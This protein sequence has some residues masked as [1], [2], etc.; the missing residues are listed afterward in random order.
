MRDIIITA[1]GSARQILQEDQT[2]L[3]ESLARLAEYEGAA[4]II[5]PTVIIEGNQASTGARAIFGTDTS[6]PRFN[7]TVSHNTA[8]P[9]SVTSSGVYTP[10]TL[11][12]LLGYSP[13]YEPPITVVQNPKH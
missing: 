9:N 11:Q 5:L 6:Q 10:E 7:L 4:Q 13:R 1:N 12:T 8:G 2:R 3:Q